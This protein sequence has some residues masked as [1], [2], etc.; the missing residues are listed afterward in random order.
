M[1]LVRINRQTSKDYPKAYFGDRR[2]VTEKALS[3]LVG[4]IV[5][6]VSM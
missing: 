4:S 2:L 6:R 5:Q 1:L 3:Q